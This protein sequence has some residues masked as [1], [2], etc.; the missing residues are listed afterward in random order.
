MKCVFC[1]LRREKD[2]KILAKTLGVEEL[3]LTK[4]D[5]R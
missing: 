2:R 3:E 4:E 1:F 5:Y